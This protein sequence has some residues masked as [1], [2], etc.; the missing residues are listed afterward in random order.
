MNK[1]NSKLIFQEQHFL[2]AIST[3]MIFAFFDNDALYDSLNTFMNAL[4]FSQ[5]FP[6]FV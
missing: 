3:N 2:N 5:H 4:T 1:L 6:V